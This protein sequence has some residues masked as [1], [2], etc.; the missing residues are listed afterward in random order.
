MSSG[1]GLVKALLSM[2]APSWLTVAHGAGGRAELGWICPMTPDGQLPAM[3][4]V[5]SALGVGVGA[6]PFWTWDLLLGHR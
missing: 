5:P 6:G 3:A 1:S 2:Y 4:L